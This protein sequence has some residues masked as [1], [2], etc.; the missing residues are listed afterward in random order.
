MKGRKNVVCFR[1]MANYIVSEIWHSEKKRNPDEEIHHIITSAA[2]LI[3]AQTL[4]KVYDTTTYP[5][6]EDIEN[7]EQSREWLPPTLQ[8]FL[9]E[10]LK[11]PLKQL[12]IG[13]C[14][15]HAM[16]PRSVIHPVPFGLGVELDHV[17]HSSA[18]I[19]ILM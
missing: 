13:Q 2:K 5:A 10:L 19:F 9:Y 6:K 18:R 1:D 12:S 7:L 8:L 4:E 11:S 15:L 16:Q 17:L 14:L 3:K